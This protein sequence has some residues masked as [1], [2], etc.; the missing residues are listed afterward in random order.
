MTAPVGYFQVDDINKTL[1]TLVQEGA[2][3]QQPAKDVG[4]GMLVA[5]VKDADG[6]VIGLLQNP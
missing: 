1:D 6:N 2:Q 5:S 3:I 4:R